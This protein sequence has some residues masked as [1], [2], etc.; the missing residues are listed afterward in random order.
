MWHSEMAPWRGLAIWGHSDEITNTRCLVGRALPPDLLR[1]SLLP[2][3]TILTHSDNPCECAG[4][5]GYCQIGNSFFRRSD[6]LPPVAESTPWLFMAEKATQD[7][8]CENCLWRPWL[9]CRAREL[10]PSSWG[11]F[12]RLCQ[13]DLLLCPLLSPSSSSGSCTPGQ[14]CTRAMQFRCR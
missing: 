9:T 1:F 10:F 6:L 8:T 12:P 4:G 2:V 3:W 5:F 13:D 11:L 7:L 14:C